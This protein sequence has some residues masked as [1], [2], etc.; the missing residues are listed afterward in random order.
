MKSSFLL[1]G[2]MS[3]L[4][5]FSC[6]NSPKNSESSIDSIGETNNNTEAIAESAPAAIKKYPVKSAIITFENDMLGIKEKSILY[7]DDYGMKET[8]VKYEGDNIKEINIC[9][10]K[11]RYTINFKEKTA[12]DVGDC[13][14]GI[15]YKFDWDEISKAD[16]KYKVKKG[17]SMHIA[18]K[19]CESYTMAAGD[20]PT[21]FAGWNNICLYQETQSKF[22]TVTMKAIKVEDNVDI[23]IEKFQIPAGFEIKKSQY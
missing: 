7:I 14:R 21:T 23:S 9:D 4:F 20:Y 6:K 22:G 10:G 1:C 17:A 5:I 13:Y 12:Y 3:T 18:G 11:K 8:D 16:Q 15:A 19:D 2:M